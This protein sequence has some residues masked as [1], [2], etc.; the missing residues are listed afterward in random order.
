MSLVWEEQIVRR[1]KAG[2]PVVEVDIRLC[3]LRQHHVSKDGMAGWETLDFN[4]PAG[5]RYVPHGDAQLGLGSTSEVQIVHLARLRA[6]ELAKEHGYQL[7]EDG[8]FTQRFKL[9]EHYPP[10]MS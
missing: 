2:T 7:V 8:A 3:V 10:N 5:Y 1:F 9:S 4:P 6:N